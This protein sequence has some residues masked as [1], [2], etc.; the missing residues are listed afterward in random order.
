MNEIAVTVVGH[1]ASKPTLRI[2]PQGHPVSSFRIASTA[3]RMDKETGGWRDTGTIFATVTA[4]RQLAEHVA[5]SLS[6]GDG[7]IV[8]G[9]LGQHEYDDREGN[10]RTSLDIDATAVGPDLSRGVA[11][12]AKAMRVPASTVP[13]AA[14][15]DE[16]D[17]WADNGTDTDADSKR[18][19]DPVPVG[20]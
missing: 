17:P 9:R 14:A 18:E 11:K 12:L 6:V 19:V 15:P 7:V 3:R 20:V 8:Q 2:T 5:Q 4:W 16:V 1:V 13:A 10:R